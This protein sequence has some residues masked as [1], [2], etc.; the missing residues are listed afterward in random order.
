ML[1]SPTAAMY[2]GTKAFITHFG[3]SLAA[4]LK[5]EGIDVCVV[6]PSPVQSNFYNEAGD[7]AEVNFFKS[8]A[9]GPEVLVGTM[10]ACIGRLVL[11]NQG[12]FPKVMGFLHKILDFTALVEIT[13]N[14]AHSSATFISVKKAAQ[15]AKKKK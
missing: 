2:A 6:H 9:K 5:S 4:E 11:C 10:F 12:Y 13:A 15:E 7:G 3:V 8:T 14:V 1:P